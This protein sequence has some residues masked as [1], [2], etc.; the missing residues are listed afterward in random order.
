[1]P[2][3]VRKYKPEDMVGRQVEHLSA[4][5]V[6]KPNVKKAAKKKQTEEERLATIKEKYPDQKITPDSMIYDLDHKKWSVE[7]TC[8][9]P[10]CTCKRRVFHADLFQ[11]KFCHEHK[12]KKKK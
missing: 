9:H 1:M 4:I 10:G 3:Y 7:I 8:Q 11:V 6:P 5:R 2:E 12:R